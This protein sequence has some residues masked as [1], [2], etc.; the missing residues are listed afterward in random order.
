[1]AAVNNLKSQTIK[2]GTVETL[3]DPEAWQ[4]KNREKVNEE[5]SELEKL[6]FR[7]IT[8]RLRARQNFAKFLMGLLVMQNML[9]F[10]IF[11]LGL[12]YGKVQGLEN[13]F[14]IIIGG[15][16]AETTSLIYII[17]KFLYSEI[18]FQSPKI[19]P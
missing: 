12:W 8:E 3:K 9:V 4:E 1:M 15:T 11:G 2:T 7:D 6:R 16:L 19:N 5:V 18:P 14:S 10:T 13:L 17:V